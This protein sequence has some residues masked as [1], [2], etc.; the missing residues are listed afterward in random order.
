MLDRENIRF[1]PDGIGPRHVTNGVKGV[2]KSLLQCHYVL[3]HGGGT[4]GSHL[5]QLC[6]QGLLD[7]HYGFGETVVNKGW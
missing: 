6:L 2:G 4:R 1:C 5:G 3:D 7:W